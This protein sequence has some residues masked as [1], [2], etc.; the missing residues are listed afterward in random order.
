MKTM[1]KILAIVTLL[2]NNSIF[3]QEDISGTW[4]GKLS[5]EGDAKLTVQ[6]IINKEAD[7]SWSALVNSPDTGGIKNVKA[8]SA[9]FDGSNLKIDVPDLSGAYKGT[10]KDGAFTGTWSQAGTTMPLNLSPYTKPVL[11]E[12]DKALLKGEWTGKVDV[13]AGALT[14]VF[15]FVTDD[16]GEFKGFIRS[17]DQGTNEMPMADIELVDGELSLKVPSWQG[18]VKGKLSSTKFAGNFVQGGRSFP[19]TMNKGK[20]EPPKSVLSLSKEIMDQLLGEWHGELD[21]PMGSMTVVYRFET[22]DAGGYTAFRESPD[23]SSNGVPVTEA[24]M[25]DGT[26][27]LKNPGPSG[28][29]N[30]KLA[31]DTISGEVKGP[32]G[33]VPLTLKKGKYIPPS[34]KLSL[35]KAAMDQI[36]GKWQG[37]LKTPQRELTLVFRFEANGDGD[38]Y[39]FVDS[40]DQGNTSL[41]VVEAALEGDELSLKTKFPKAEFRGKLNGDELDGQWMQ[42]PG[43][44]P[45]TM[46]KE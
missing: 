2:A 7:G 46:K 3:A 5:L 45:L 6:F 24:T 31:G 19:L 26:L 15:R 11:L 29:F 1:I 23:Q 34:Y 22:N 27:T 20:Y 36:Q 37:K 18:D 9:G 16:A 10:Y 42:G 33:A 4:Q 41:K 12:A 14:L 38:Y 21:T 32:L 35:S 43:T 17:P 25:T 39:G 8:S 40:P 28:E 13:P 30:G 44:M